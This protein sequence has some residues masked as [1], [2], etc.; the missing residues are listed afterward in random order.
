MN[1][2]CLEGASQRLEGGWGGPIY[3][4]TLPGRGVPKLGSVP[5]AALGTA[6]H[7]SVCL[8]LWAWLHT[9][10]ELGA[11]VDSGSCSLS[12]PCPS[13]QTFSSHF[14][15]SYFLYLTLSPHSQLNCL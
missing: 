14:L 7:C 10:P 3:N 6:P 1:L 8:S 9:A 4:G 12:E 13:P 15:L 2:G 11:S 5:A